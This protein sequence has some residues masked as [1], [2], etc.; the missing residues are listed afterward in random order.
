MPSAQRRGNTRH[1]RA[2]AAVG[3]TVLAASGL[4][5]CGSSGPSGDTLN[6]WTLQD[7]STDIQREFVEQFNADS[8]IDIRITEIAN[9]GYTDRLRTAMG[10]ENAPDIF[11][12]WGGGSISEYVEQ[13]MLV[14]LTPIIEEEAELRDGFVDTILDAGAVDGQRYGIPMRG[15]QPVILFY[16]QT[17]FA[18]NG[19][20]P[21]Q[22]LDDL[23]N[24]VDT[25]TAEGITPFAL[26][27]SEPWTELMWLEYLLDREGG[28]EVFQTI[29]GGDMSAWN[30]PAV[31]SMAEN[32]EQ[33][34]DAGAFGDNFRSVQYGNDAASTL[35]AR[36]DAAM[37]LMGAWEY[38]NQLG[39]QP[40]FAEADLA[41][42][43]FPVI[44]GGA[45]DPNGVVGNPTNYWSIHS[46]VEGERLD[47][48]VEF[49]KLMATED[50]AQALIDNG[51][52]PAT[53]NAADLLDSAPNPEFATWQ[54]EMINNATSFQLSW[55]QALTPQYAQPMLNAIQELFAGQIGP[56]EFV[57]E[58]S[59]L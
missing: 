38:S 10:T 2:L 24:A 22:T 20:E 28:P 16:N 33:L 30:D 43:A 23:Y 37:H 44:E 21:P 59:S 6:V 47:A 45:G 41:Y 15:V 3:A 57:D 48:A 14:D 11:F 49:M 26:A 13:D 39:N 18:D 19:L 52:I 54:Y 27:G 50:Y 1:V 29:Q 8:D 40:E 31:L 25:L 34:V 51:D 4:A 36:G 46:N 5:A 42:T 32:V 9:D 12:N 7:P 17:L 35:F 53:S 55:D 56:Q 58:M